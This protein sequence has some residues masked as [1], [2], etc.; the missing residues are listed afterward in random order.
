MTTLF[1]DAN[2]LNNFFRDQ[3]ILDETN[4]PS[5]VDDETSPFSLEAIS[6]SPTEVESILKSLSLG[7]ASVPDTFN[8]M[9]LKELSEELSTTLSD[10][11]NQS[12]RTSQFPEP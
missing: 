4:T 2:I 11:F 10:L 9:I 12:L 1:E 8:N 7:K 5:I 6:T 3:T